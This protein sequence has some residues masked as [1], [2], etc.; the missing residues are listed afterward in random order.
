MIEAARKDVIMIT[1]GSQKWMN[2]CRVA[3]RVEA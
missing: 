1:T 3:S 2:S